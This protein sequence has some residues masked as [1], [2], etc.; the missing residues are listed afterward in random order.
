MSASS[1]RLS[2]VTTKL[3]SN[4]QGV[5]S[6]VHSAPFPFY[7]VKHPRRPMFGQSKPEQEHSQRSR[8][9]LFLTFGAAVAIARGIQ[10]VIICENGVGAIN[11]PVSW[12][13]LGAQTSRSVHPKTLVDMEQL[14]GLIGTYNVHY[15]SP[16]T[17]LTKGELCQYINDE[18][19]KSLCRYTVSCDS[20]PLHERKPNG[21]GEL[22]CGTCTS[23]VFRRLAI[24]V[25]SLDSYDPPHL[26]KVDVLRPTLHKKL[27][28]SEQAKRLLD[29]VGTIREVYQDAEPTASMLAAFPELLTAIEAVTTSP[30]T[31]SFNQQGGDVSSQLGGL[32]QRYA[33][34]WK[35]FDLVV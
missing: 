6:R 11:L 2:S 10:D 3:I 32:Y 31:F 16:Y 8:G 23:C 1:R 4:I 22:H 15:K 12:A 9:F 25:A 14:L 24:H 28:R 5:S 33:N 27:V 19:L 35:T 18:R 26:Y 20:F 34:E 7:M 29:Q 13:Q 30:S 21:D 17:F